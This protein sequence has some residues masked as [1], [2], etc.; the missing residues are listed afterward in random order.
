M[1]LEDVHPDSRAIVQEII[2][3]GDVTC[4]Q[5]SCYSEEGVMEVKNKACDAL[6]AH[7]VDTKMK[8]TKI[9]SI[10]NRIHVA[11]PKPRDDV[12]RT[13]FIPEAVK[14]K[15]KYDKTDPNRK[16]LQ[17][18]IELEEGGAGVYNIN[19]RRMF[20]CIPFLF[21]HDW[22]ISTEDYILANPEWKMDV[23]PEIMDGKNI[24]DFIDPDI[25]EKLEALEREEEKL[26][27]EGFYDS[28]SDMVNKC[29][30]SNS[31]LIHVFFSYQFDSDDEREAQEAQ[32]ALSHKIKSQSIKKSKKNQ[33]R[34]PRTAGLRTLSELT[35]ELT[36][37]GLDP[38][39]IQERAEMI[40]KLQGAK[41]KR[42]DEDEDDDEEMGDAEEDGS[43]REAGGDGWMDV[44]D[45]DDDS[46]PKKRVKTNSGR[47]INKREPRSHRQMAGMR[48]E[49]VSIYYFSPYK[50][51]ARNCF[52]FFQQFD[53]AN[54]LRN[55][56][57][58]PRNMLAKAGEGDRAIKTKMVRFVLVLKLSFSRIL[59]FFFLYPA[60]ASVRRKTQSR[61]DTKKMTAHPPF[62]SLHLSSLYTCS[63]IV[64]DCLIYSSIMTVYYNLN[65]IEFPKS[66][67]ST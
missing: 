55:L 21:S 39:R 16:R 48:D 62:L 13:P 58:R 59:P 56:G 40:A 11:Q 2:D 4:V 7:R 63:T 36:K 8:G 50:G 25:A 5:V 53:R 42:A 26:Q 37:A 31:L 60:Q 47:V 51:V 18:D 34:L 22:P 45:D 17:R 67:Y 54:K 52:F 66:I 32:V 44:D 3:Q 10:I 24:A 61:E 1:R 23:I 29:I 43:E 57:Q 9:N 65:D 41:R 15:K 27:A 35:S 19:L 30:F 20:F 12:V 28:D 14:E 64:Y 46:A 38:S 49:A 33:A 6:L